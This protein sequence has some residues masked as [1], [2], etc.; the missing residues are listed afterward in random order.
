MVLEEADDLMDYNLIAK[1]ALAISLHF[2]SSSTIDGT[3][4]NQASAECPTNLR[5]SEKYDK[6]ERT[7]ILITSIMSG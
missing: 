5:Q 1:G 4:S 2:Y 7:G 3:W 6:Q